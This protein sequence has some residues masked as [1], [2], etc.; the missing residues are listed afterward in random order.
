MAFM[1]F[2]EPTNDHWNVRIHYI[3][4]Q[5]WLCDEQASE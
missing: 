4:S 5:A 1:Y 3:L 2:R